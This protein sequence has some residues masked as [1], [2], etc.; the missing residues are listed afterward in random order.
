MKG[1]SVATHTLSHA[2]SHV[3]GKPG[4]KLRSS[5]GDETSQETLERLKT[6]HATQTNS[7]Q[8]VGTV[9]GNKRHFLFKNICLDARYMKLFWQRFRAP[10]Q[11]WGDYVS[12]WVMLGML[13]A[14]VHFLIMHRHGYP[15]VRAVQ[16]K[17]T[18]LG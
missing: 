9:T 17:H 11:P 6:L 7:C 13:S 4:T 5:E 2:F 8:F 10:S 15:V 3:C 14:D 16:A 12:T 18:R 1:R